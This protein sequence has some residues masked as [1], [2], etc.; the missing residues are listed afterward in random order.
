MLHNKFD[1]LTEAVLDLS[2][3][4]RLRELFGEPIKQDSPRV[5]RYII[6]TVHRRVSSDQ[7]RN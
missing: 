7:E 2:I 3:E 1:S 6:R 4:S 5:W